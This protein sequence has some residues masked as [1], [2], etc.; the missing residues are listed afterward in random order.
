[1]STPS[2]T[3]YKAAQLDLRK[4]RI[5][6]SFHT[7]SLHARRSWPQCLLSLLNQKV[8]GVKIEAVD[9]LS[10]VFIENP[11]NIFHPPRKDS[12]IK[13]DDEIAEAANFSAFCCHFFFVI[14]K[15]LEEKQNK[16]KI[17]LLVIFKS[18][19]HFNSNF[20]FR[21]ERASKAF[22]INHRPTRHAKRNCLRTKEAQLATN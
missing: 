17:C 19:L 6:I 4:T 8:V 10:I 5:P 20:T 22:H 18:L 15:V 2:P 14:L 13:R 16:L 12:D 11:I 3:L 1:M 21:L 7:I 9:S